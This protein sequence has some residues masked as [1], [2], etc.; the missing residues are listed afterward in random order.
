MSDDK[1]KEL[2][3]SERFLNWAKA[4][5]VILPIIGA[6]IISVLG[7]FK[8]N[9]AQGDV[10]SLILQLDKRVAKQEQVINAQSEKLEKMARRMIFFQAHQTGFSAGSLYEKNQQ[11]EKTVAELRAKKVVRVVTK[12]RVRKVPSKLE[13]DD[14][15][16]QQQIPR[17][18]APKPFKKE[19]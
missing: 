15:I 8:G 5:G 4:L 16:M 14:P 9:D 3:P 13:K 1:K 2:A 17:L 11:L 10:D 18:P 6:A 7:W 19:D 12:E